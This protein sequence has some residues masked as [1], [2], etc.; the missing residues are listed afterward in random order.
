MTLAER[1]VMLERMAIPV[2]LIDYLGLEMV[3]GNS[4]ALALWGAADLAEFKA[5]DIK[6]VSEAAR[7]RQLA[8]LARSERGETEELLLT[9][10]PRGK[11]AMTVRCHFSGFPLDDGR[12]VVLVQAMDAKVDI[13]AEE[14][15]G[16]EALRRIWA[17]VTLLDE[18][19]AVLTQNPAALRAFGDGKPLAEWFVDSGVPAAMAA[20]VGAGQVFRRE[21]KAHTLAGERWHSVEAHRT[22]DPVTGLP[23]TLVL[24]MDV[25]GLHDSRAQIEQQAAQIRMLS[26]PI[27][28][29]GE[30]VLAVPLI[31][32][33]GDHR[34]GELAER[35]LTEVTARR[36]QHVILD[37]TGVDAL[38]A[39]GAASLMKVV[40]AT[41]LLGARPIM[42]GIGSKLAEMLVHSGSNLGGILTLRSLWSGLAACRPGT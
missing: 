22:V 35:L 12:T 11:S 23:A 32:E 39:K 31:G 37:L 30:G 5:R 36:A 3:W 4:R 10:Y 42:T 21:V 26:M 38:D 14:L 40:R 8:T 41:E 15:R 9:F 6:Q 20:E 18:A 16:V 19:G 13:G 1:L 34:I 27:L 25:T 17:M 33:L 29:V 7:T 24:Q 28:D 2:W